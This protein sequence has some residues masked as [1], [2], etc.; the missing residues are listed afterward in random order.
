M[1]RIARNN[2]NGR[3]NLNTCSLAEGVTMQC[4]LGLKSSY[5]ILIENFDQLI[6]YISFF[7]SLTIV[8]TFRIFT[9]SFNGKKCNGHTIFP[10][11]VMVEEPIK[12]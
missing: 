10:L 4:K 1:S 11:S 12:R 3:L 7:L 6:C 5:N 2:V 8:Q 9:F